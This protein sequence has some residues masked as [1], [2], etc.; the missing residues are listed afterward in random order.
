MLKQTGITES[1]LE[2][3][4]LETHL[5]QVGTSS[6]SDI[7]V[8]FKRVERKRK[9]SPEPSPTPKRTRQKQ[10]AVRPLEKKMT[11]KKKVKK[12]IAPIEKLLREIIGDGKLKNI[13]KMYNTL[14]DDDKESI[15]NSVIVHLD[16]YKKFLM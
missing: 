2:A 8:V 12:T 3:L 5:S 10:Q 11:P 15:E 7:H 14:S 6:E 13:N 9:P 4:Q 16:I 1:E